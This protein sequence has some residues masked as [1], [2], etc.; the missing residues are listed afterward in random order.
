MA[1]TPLGAA[2][3][4]AL[5]A[6][7]PSATASATGPDSPDGERPRS[8]EVG[9]PPGLSIEGTNVTTGAVRPDDG[10]AVEGGSTA[11]PVPASVLALAAGLGSLGLLQILA[12]LRDRS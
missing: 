10:T 3:S 6:L 11:V 9:L 12:G 7:L 5:V 4:L 1:R 8:A 2:A